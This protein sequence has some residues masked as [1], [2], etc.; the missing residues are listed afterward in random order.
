[1]GTGRR[2]QEASRQESRRFRPHDQMRASMMPPAIPRGCGLEPRSFSAEGRETSAVLTRTEVLSTNSS[3]PFLPAD[4]HIPAGPGPFCCPSPG[5]DV[6]LIQIPRGRAPAPSRGR[7][8]LPTGS[9]VAAAIGRPP[10]S[11]GPGS[12]VS[13]GAGAW[14]VSGAGSAVWPVSGAGAGPCSVP[15]DSPVPGSSS[16]VEL[17]PPTAGSSVVTASSAAP[18]SVFAGSSSCWAGLSF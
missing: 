6:G 7:D 17:F 2:R 13:S 14:V 3:G 5:R 4:G 10:C 16:S 15:F 12:R 11:A 9:G 1:M 8:L 18:S